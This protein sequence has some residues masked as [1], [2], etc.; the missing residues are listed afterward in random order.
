MYTAPG[1]CSF[2]S[3]PER[4]LISRLSSNSLRQ[5]CDRGR[6]SGTCQNRNSP[7]SVQ[8]WPGQRWGGERAEISTEQ[9]PGGGLGGQ[10][11][12]LKGE[13]RNE[14]AV[15]IFRFRDRVDCNIKVRNP[16]QELVGWEK[17]TSRTGSV[18]S[19]KFKMLGHKRAT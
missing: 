18:E 4:E 6:K 16:G 10:Q 13:G 17:G 11:A 14:D 19:I 1:S 9:P 7:A 5:Q 15:Q 3:E 2:I 8:T 12:E